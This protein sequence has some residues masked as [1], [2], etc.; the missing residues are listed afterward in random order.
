MILLVELEVGMA[1]LTLD[2]SSEERAD[3]AETM[4]GDVPD[5]DADDVAPCAAGLAPAV[6]DD[7][8]AAPAGRVGVGSDVVVDDGGVDAVDGC[9]GVEAHGSGG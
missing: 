2:L 1:F 4:A 8:G 5:A 7:G 6:D 9:W 3:G